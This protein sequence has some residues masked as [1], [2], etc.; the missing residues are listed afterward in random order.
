[1][2]RMKI[3]LQDFAAKMQGGGLC[4]RGPYLRDTMV[5]DTGCVFNHIQLMMM[6]YDMQAES[7]CEAVIQGKFICLW[8]L[9]NHKLNLSH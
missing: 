3:P 7:I 8:D 4:A 6:V 9:G 5:Y 1:M 2:R